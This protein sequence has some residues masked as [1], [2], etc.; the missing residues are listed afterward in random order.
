MNAGPDRGAKSL[1]EIIDMEKMMNQ[2]KSQA[3]RWLVE[4]CTLLVILSAASPGFAQQSKQAPAQPKPQVASAPSAAASPT[5]SNPAAKPAG[6]EKEA[7]TPDDAEDG[8]IKI[9]GHCVLE[10]KNPNGKV[11]DRRE[12]NNSLV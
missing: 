3:A 7:A 8:G 6:E 10:L 2:S 12:F 1:M 5:A 4:A 11:V 9:H